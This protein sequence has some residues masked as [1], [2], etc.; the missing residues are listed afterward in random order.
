MAFEVADDKDRVII[1]AND[2]GKIAIA[3]FP[4]LSE[5]YKEY[6]IKTYTKNLIVL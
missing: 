6:I 2:N 4:D 5:E 3:R 1:S